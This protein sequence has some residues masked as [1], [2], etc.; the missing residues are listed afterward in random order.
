[1][2]DNMAAA[3]PTVVGGLI[4]CSSATPHLGSLFPLFHVPY[5]QLGFELT[6]TYKSGEKNMVSNDL[7]INVAS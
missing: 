3:S 1:M 7:H 2:F 6:A 5:I 4:F